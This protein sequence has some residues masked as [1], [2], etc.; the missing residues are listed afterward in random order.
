MQNVKVEFNIPK[1]IIF[2]LNE[3]INEFKCKMIN[4]MAMEFYDKGNYLLEKHQNWQI[5]VKKIL[6]NYYLIIIT[7]SLIGITRK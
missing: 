5:S 6:S 2:Q 4:N 7:V 3:S 1:D